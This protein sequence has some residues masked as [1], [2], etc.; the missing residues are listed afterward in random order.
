MLAVGIGGGWGLWDMTGKAPKKLRV[1]GGGG[2]T[3]VAFTPN[4]K[5]VVSASIDGKVTTT[6]VTGN[7]KA[8]PVPLPPGLESI[9][10]FAVA[11]DGRHIALGDNKRKVYILRLA[12][13]PS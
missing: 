2:V 3:R 5:T 4:G 11:S 7:W 8:E 9:H 12:P 6:D 13:A 1:M 10:S